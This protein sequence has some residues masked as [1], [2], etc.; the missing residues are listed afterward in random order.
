MS[1]L[2]LVL[3]SNPLTPLENA[4]RSVL[5]WLHGSI[6]LQ[7]SWSIVALTVIVR[8]LLVPLTVGAVVAR[9]GD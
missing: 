5:D 8:L 9:A 2:G 4:M 1:L 3:A 7:W 6:G